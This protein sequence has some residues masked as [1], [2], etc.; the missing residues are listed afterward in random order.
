[1]KTLRLY[2]YLHSSGGIDCSGQPGI[3][4]NCKT[5][6]LSYFNSSVV[7]YHCNRTLDTT[8]AA[9]APDITGA[10]GLPVATGVT[11]IN[12]TNLITGTNGI[13]GAADSTGATGP[14]GAKRNRVL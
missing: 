7:I 1:M 14:T 9:A 3:P 8:A 4:A 10:A 13:T 6:T 12:K 5:H 11:D 2:P